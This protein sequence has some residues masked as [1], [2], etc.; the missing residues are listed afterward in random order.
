MDNHFVRF[1]IKDSK[2]PRPVFVAVEHVAQYGALPRSAPGT[3]IISVGMRDETH[4]IESVEQVGI[5][6]LAARQAQA[7][8]E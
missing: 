8:E 7:Q 2:E 4:V 5:A 6:L 1:T 3:W